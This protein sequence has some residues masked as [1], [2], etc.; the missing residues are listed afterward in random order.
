MKTLWLSSTK[1][2][3]LNV[4][5]TEIEKIIFLHIQKSFIIH[6]SHSTTLNV[7]EKKIILPND[8][9]KNPSKI[10]KKESKRFSVRQYNKIE[11][12]E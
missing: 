6:N 1:D 4:E 11:M 7:T 10:I 9:E 2:R 5:S 12:L 8:S 3:K